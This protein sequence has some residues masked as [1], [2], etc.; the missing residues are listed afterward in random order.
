MDKMIDA[1]FLLF[2]GTIGGMV[3]GGIMSCGIQKMVINSIMIK[4]LLFFVIIFFTNSFVSGD[5]QQPIITLFKS[6][7]IYIL[8]ML[9]MKSEKEAVITAVTLM[10]VYYISKEQR[11]YLEKCDADN[12]MISSLSLI[13]EYIS[14]ATAL[15]IVLGF[16]KYT[17]RQASERGDDFDVMKFMFGHNQCDGLKGGKTKK[18]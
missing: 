18:L 12:E 15:V 16:V 14:Y 17:H 8:F 9:L 1:I 13:E 7:L 11:K 6:F 10:A 2:L 3:G 4:H 5:V